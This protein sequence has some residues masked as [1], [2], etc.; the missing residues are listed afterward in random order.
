MIFRLIRESHRFFPADEGVQSHLGGTA[1]HQHHEGDILRSLRRRGRSVQD[2]TYL[3]TAQ[4]FW[5]QTHTRLL[6]RRG[7]V[8]GGS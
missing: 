6:G 5:G 1:L 7:L 2:Q 4:V 8:T 3:G